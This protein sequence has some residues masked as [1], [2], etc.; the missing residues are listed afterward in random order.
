MDLGMQFHHGV[1]VSLSSM[2]LF[3][4]LLHMFQNTHPKKTNFPHSL[5]GKGMKGVKEVKEVKGMKGVKGVKGM[6]NLHPL[7]QCR[8]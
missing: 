5:L 4:S 1:V 3:L 7:V 8:H 2:S 6:K